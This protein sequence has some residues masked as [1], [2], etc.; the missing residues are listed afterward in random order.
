MQL[1]SQILR[2]NEEYL[3]SAASLLIINP[4]EVDDL[5]FLQPKKVLSFNYRV[6]HS[7]KDALE[8]IVQFGAHQKDAQRYSTALVYLPKAK[9]ELD[10]TLALAGSMLEQG[11]DLYLVG[12]KKGGISS[13]AKKLDLIGSG[14]TKLDSAKHCQFWH[15]KAEDYSNKPFN[16]SD[17]VQFYIC[18]HQGIAF[19]LATIPGVFSF[20]RL[21]DGSAQLLDSMPSN[22]RGRNL[23]FGC[24]SGAIGIYAAKKNPDI[25]LEMVDTNWLALECAKISCK[26]NDIDAKIY[27]SDGWAEVEGRVNGVM[28]NPPFHQGISTE[29][30][31]TE[32]FIRTAKDKLTKHAP[33]LLVANSFLKYPPIIESTFER[34]DTLS[35]NKKFSVYLAR[36]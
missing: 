1:S 12:E 31:T 7:H 16:L 36:R 20:G 11:A 13:A 27:P 14:A 25:S 17:W 19:K 22:L 8:E 29:Y 10:L 5:S 6:V 30:N 33:F 35:E 28:T 34:W 26:E 32:R 18:E 23:D 3:A 21:D 4:P 24:G 9:G 15:V 2:R